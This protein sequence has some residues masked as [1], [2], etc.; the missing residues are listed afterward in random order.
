M[1]GQWVV[2]WSQLCDQI[3]EKI[4]MSP[5]IKDHVPDNWRINDCADEHARLIN[6]LQWN[7]VKHVRKKQCDPIN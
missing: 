7:F 6:D 2:H 4:K 1:V 5:C 3:Y